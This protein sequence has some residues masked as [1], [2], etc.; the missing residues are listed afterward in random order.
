VAPAS[1]L[2]RPVFRATARLSILAG[3]VST[4]VT[5][6]VVAVAIPKIDGGL[7]VLAGLTATASGVSELAYA[8]LRAIGRVRVEAIGLVAE[9]L[10]FVVVAVLALERYRSAVSVMAVYLGL[11]AIAA[12]VTS[13]A[14]HRLAPPASDA[15]VPDVFDAEARRSAL[16]FALV[17]V[18]PRLPTIVL[19]AIGGP[20]P[21]G[22]LA[23]ALRPVESVVLVA[24]SSAQPLLP[25]LRQRIVAGTR[26]LA[27]RA[28]V[29]VAAALA[30]PAA[31]V[32]AALIAL[33]E[34]LVSVLLDDRESRAAERAC[35]ILGAVCL[36]WTLR[37]VAE[38]RL[39]AEERA[40]TFVTIV[41]TGVVVTAAAVAVGSHVDGTVGAAWA[42]LVA[43]AVQLACCL[44][45][46]PSLRSASALRGYAASVGVGVVAAL[47]FLAVRSSTPAAAVAGAVLLALAGWLGLRSLRAVE[48]GVAA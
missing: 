28:T 48:A 30:A 8:G 41:V 18:G 6:A 37:G 17:T 39:F 25:V 16:S 43:E 4:V 2:L 35:G 34:Q 10:V 19:G 36:T 1:T 33:P 24:H 42:V 21:A 29:A 40:G 13:A 31:V 7:V 3:L 15:P 22:D 32:G 27:D 9:R 5:C 11:N 23:L 47:V 46:V 14:V 38:L 20:V 45:A 12:V 44:A 26:A